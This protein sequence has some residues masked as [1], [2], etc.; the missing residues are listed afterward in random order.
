MRENRFIFQ[1]FY[2]YLFIRDLQHDSEPGDFKKIG[3]SVPN[4]I[5]ISSTTVHT[6]VLQLLSPPRPHFEIPTVRLL[7]AGSTMGWTMIDDGVR[8][9][10]DS[11]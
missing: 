9:Q 10:S 11:R 6:Y 2:T 4:K 8:D 7:G 3:Q 1:I 5:L